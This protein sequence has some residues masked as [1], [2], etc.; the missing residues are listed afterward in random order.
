ME[1]CFYLVN[2]S[3]DSFHHQ[4]SEGLSV[5]PSTKHF[6]TVT[7]VSSMSS[8]E[9]RILQRKICSDSEEIME[10]FASLRINAEH[11][12][13][14]KNCEISKLLTCI[15]DVKHVKTASKESPLHELK[16]ATSVSDVFLGLFERNLISFLQFSI[17]KRVIKKLCVDSSE[18]QEQLEGYDAHFNAYIKRRV[19]ESSIY[20][21]GR[22]EVFTG[23]DSEDKVELLIITDDNWDDYTQ[24]MKV[25]DLERIVANS[26]NF[27][28][29]SLQ[30]ASIE[31]QCLRIRYTISL[32]IVNSVFPL[33]AEE[34]KELTCN[35]IVE[36]KCLEFCYAKQEKCMLQT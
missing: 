28:R 6:S 1:K 23:C 15:M 25:L 4:T 9:W 29:F 14:E 13:L 22:F 24:F 12:L 30:L 35:G 17:V 26:L 21:E 34:W 27:D 31:P 20:H 3:P 7:N 18:L 8:I 5:I 16:T 11:Y 32:H 19:C 2:N 10:E 36:M 33:T